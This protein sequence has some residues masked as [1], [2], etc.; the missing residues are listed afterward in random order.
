M[1]DYQALIDD[2]DRGELKYWEENLS[3]CHFVPHTY[4]MG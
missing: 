3:Q 2:S 4:D 1:N